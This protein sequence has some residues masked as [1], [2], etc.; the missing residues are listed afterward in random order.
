MK[1]TPILINVVIFSALALGT[2]AFYGDVVSVYRPAN[3]TS[4]EDFLVFNETFTEYND[5]MATLEQRTVGASTKQWTD[6]SKYYD[7]TMA[8][9][10]VG[11]LLFELPNLMY[12]FVSVTGDV[13]PVPI[14]AWFTVMVLSIITVI[15]A[16][17][18]SGVFTK[19]DEI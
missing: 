16:L 15:F 5:N 10:G 4:E 14:P 17:R 12:K 3:S 18:I 13:L 9:I 2:I 6:W 7:A 1:L 8:F 11:A 19:T